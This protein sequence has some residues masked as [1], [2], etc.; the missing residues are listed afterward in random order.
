MAAQLDGRRAL[1]TGGGT[2]IGRACAAALA[3]AGADVTVFGRREAPLRAMVEAGSARRFVVGDVRAPDLSAEFDILVNAAGVARSAPFLRSDESLWR[4]MLD[5]N[6]MGAVAVT[7]A[8]LPGMLERRN[9]RVIHIASTASLRGYAYTSAYA[10]SKH[11]LL[12]FVRSLAIECATR[13]VTVNAV[14]PG[15]TDTD[16]VAESVANIVARTGRSAE[17]AAAELARFNPQG[18]LVRPEEVA[19]AVLFLASDAASAVNGQ[20]IAVDGGET[21]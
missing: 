4:E 1:V 12:G 9:G 14:C 20:A 21:Q 8:V 6:L 16:I 7:R 18:R 3:A 11:A 5:V 19:S 15:F 2:G 13:G 17:E 10:A